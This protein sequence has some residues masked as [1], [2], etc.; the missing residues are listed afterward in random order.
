MIMSDKSPC[1]GPPSVK[2]RRARRSAQREDRKNKSIPR[3]R[4]EKCQTAGC[5]CRIRASQVRRDTKACQFHML[6]DLFPLATAPSVPPPRLIFLTSLTDSR[7]RCQRIRLV[8]VHIKPQRLRSQSC[9]GPPSHH[10]TAKLRFNLVPQTEFIMTMNIKL[11]VEELFKNAPDRYEK[12]RENPVTGGSFV[13]SLDPVG[14]QKL[15]AERALEAQEWFAAQKPDDAPELPLTKERRERIK[16]GQLSFIVSVFARSLAYRDFR[17]EG[18]P[19]FD[20]Y[21]RGVMAS[22]WTPKWIREDAQLLSRYP[23]NP[24]KGMGGGLIWR[25]L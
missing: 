7:Q 21:A 8:D 19:N 4:K 14:P 16:A 23:P 2:A 13:A 10:R 12:F 3:T 17:T 24:L 6:F 20:E 18:H 9:R 11:K 25:G 15:L 1:K 22:D 5:R